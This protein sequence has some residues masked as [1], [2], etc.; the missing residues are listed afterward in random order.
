MTLRTAAE[1]RD[2]LAQGEWLSLG[3]AAIV[4]DAARN[5]VHRMLTA[6]PPV[7]R[8]RLK[9]GS[10]RHRELHPGDVLAQLERRSRVHGEP[11]DDAPS[12]DVDGHKAD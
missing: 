8:F 1:L 2:A 10:G 4:L 5:T 12:A 3:E 9:P 7:I 11:D 6:V